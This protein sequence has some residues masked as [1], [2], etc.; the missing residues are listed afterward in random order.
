[1]GSNT[2]KEKWIES[3]LKLEAMDESYIYQVLI[4]AQ[5]ERWYREHG[6]CKSDPKWAND[7]E[8]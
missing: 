2:P 4:A 7:P 5:D 1:M 3:I 8:S 6:L